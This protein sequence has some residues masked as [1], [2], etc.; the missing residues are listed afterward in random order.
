[1]VVQGC[2]A[3]IWNMVANE[4]AVVYVC[5]D[6]SVGSSVREALAR[7]AKEHGKLSIFSANVCSY[8]FLFLFYYVILLFYIFLSSGHFTYLP[9]DLGAKAW[10]NQ[11]TEVRFFI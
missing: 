1:M 8:R 6:V 7:V 9:V 5:G 11:A 3:E 10:G 4:G 2:G